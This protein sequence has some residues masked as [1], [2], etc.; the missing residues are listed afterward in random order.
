MSERLKTNRP[1]GTASA[2]DGA[3][4][5][6]REGLESAMEK[7]QSARALTLSLA[8][9]TK[10]VAPVLAARHPLPDAR[11]LLDVGG[12]TGIYAIA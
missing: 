8:G 5:I 12:G 7:E 2:Q 3:A 1:A 6:Y 11:V 9:R 10:N 4:F